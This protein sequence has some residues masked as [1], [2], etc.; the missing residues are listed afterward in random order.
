MQTYTIIK[1]FT[2]KQFKSFGLPTKVSA[3]KAI[4]DFNIPIRLHDTPRSYLKKI[5]TALKNGE[6]TI[7]AKK[8]KQGDTFIR[9]V[10]SKSPIQ[11]KRV[12]RK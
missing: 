2:A 10:S 5:A 3:L 6:P 4:I 8:W 9:P 12:Q 11:T 7:L 1:R